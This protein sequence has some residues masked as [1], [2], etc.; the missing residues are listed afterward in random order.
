MKITTQQIKQIISEELNKLLYEEEDNSEILR[1]AMIKNIR[2]NDFDKYYDQIKQFILNHY[3]KI[4]DPQALQDFKQKVLPNLDNIDTL[5]SFFGQ[6]RSFV[7]FD[8]E[9]EEYEKQAQEIE[10]FLDAEDQKS[11]LADRKI[12]SKDFSRVQLR[13]ANLAGADLSGANLSDANLS[14]ANLSDAN[15]SGANLIGVDLL[16]VNLT[17]A[18]LSGANL[19]VVDLSGANLT[20]ADL[21]GANLT[22]AD[23]MDTLYNDQTVWPKGFD[24]IAAGAEKV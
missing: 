10:E 21:S 12:E 1:Q 24:P 3:Q 9:D 14:E 15:L 22:G 8:E 6:F 23:L 19:S 13:G 18:N 2:D 11:F 20:G 17:G 16:E 4:Q 5:P 7:Y